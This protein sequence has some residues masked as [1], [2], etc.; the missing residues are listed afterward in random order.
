MDAA[1]VDTLARRLGLNAVYAP[2]SRDETGRGFGNA[3]LTRGRLTDVVPLTLPHTHPF[4]GQGR[5]AVLATIRFADRALR[6]ASVHLETPPLHFERR[7]EQAVVVSDTLACTGLPLVIGGDFNTVSARMGDLVG[8]LLRR[9]GLHRVDTGRDDPAERRFLGIPIDR[10]RLD[11]LFVRGLEV[12]AAGVVRDTR[13]SD[14]RPIWARLARADDGGPEVTAGRGATV[15]AAAP[16]GRTSVAL[17]ARRPGRGHGGGEAHECVLQQR[18]G[19][20]EVEPQEAGRTEVGS[21]R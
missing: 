4:T 12:A 20:A 14:Q 18:V 9:Q 17:P 16:A 1:G 15:G 3:I 7:L 6:V 2:A 21:I 8:H 13:A 5:M 19:T 10:G 11:H